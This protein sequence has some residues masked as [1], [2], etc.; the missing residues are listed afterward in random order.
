MGHLICMQRPYIRLLLLFLIYKIRQIHNIASF[1]FASRSFG[2][3]FLNT[4]S[5]VQLEVSSFLF[6]CYSVLPCR[7]F[8]LASMYNRLRD[9]PRTRR[10]F[11]GSY[12][13]E[14][15]I[16]KSSTY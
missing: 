8:P 15:S 14:T 3:N 9:R 1:Q 4:F 13:R 16:Y 10:V 11:K 6:G 12:R 7:A 5:N 2:E